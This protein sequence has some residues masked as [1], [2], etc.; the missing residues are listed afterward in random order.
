MTL[1]KVISI[2]YSMA[3]F[4]IFSTLSADQKEAILNYPL[5]VTYC[6]GSEESRIKWFKRIN[7]P[8]TILTNQELRNATYLGT[9]LESAKNG[10]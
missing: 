7:Q 5:D 2:S 6:I 10:F 8:N 9:F 1:L 4:V 3:K